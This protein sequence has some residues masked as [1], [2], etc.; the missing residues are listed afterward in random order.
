MVF[1][2]AAAR[3]PSGPSWRS[4]F[5]SIGTPADRP[6]TPENSLDI[7]LLPHKLTRLGG[8]LPAVASVMLGFNDGVI[9]IGPATVTEGD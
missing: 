7:V 1:T 5:E 6:P 3:S 8:Y 9:A 2:I 4:H